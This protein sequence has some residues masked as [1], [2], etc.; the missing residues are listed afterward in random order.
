MDVER[1]KRKE[2]VMAVALVTGGS[3]GLGRALATELARQG[4]AVVVDGRRRDLLEEIVHTD[5]PGSI[6]PIPGDIA[7]PRHRADLVAAVLQYGRLDLLVNNA[8][9]LGA[10]PLPRL[11]EYPLEEFGAVLD[12]DVVAPLA[13]TQRLLPLLQARDGIIVNVS[14]DA[15]VE[16]Y[17]G[18]GAY[19]AAKAALD[20]ISAVLAVEE[21]RLRVYSFD[22]GD[23]RTEMHQQAYP[24]EDISDRPLP[25]TVVPALMRLVDVRPPS[26]RYRA[27][28]L[29]GASRSDMAAAG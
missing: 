24:D 16:A 5:G 1:R 19:G 23:M 17:P 7:D 14:S 15:A 13:L 4:W 6:M 2:D 25:E 9:R 3:R 27:A 20:R 22:P 18:W 11:A 26:G 8:S 21:S 10:S 29:S 28:D 12:V